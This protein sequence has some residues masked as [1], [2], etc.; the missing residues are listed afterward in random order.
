LVPSL[1]HWSVTVAT[2]AAGNLSDNTAVIHSAD[3]SFQRSG[4]CRAF[5]DEPFLREHDPKLVQVSPNG[6]KH[7]AAIRD[8]YALTLL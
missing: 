5:T 2:S 7:P 8:K 1:T 3:T 6:I 4:M